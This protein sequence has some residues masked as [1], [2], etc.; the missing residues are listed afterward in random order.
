MCNYPL[1]L[2]QRLF[3]LILPSDGTAAGTS[4]DGLY[5]SIQNK[6]TLYEEFTI[7]SSTTTVGSAVMQGGIPGGPGSGRPPM[8]R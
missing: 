6:G 7:S 3:L 8:M 1:D 4:I 2:S 5:D